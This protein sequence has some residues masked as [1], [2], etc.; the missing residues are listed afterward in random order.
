MTERYF[1]KFPTISYNNSTVVDITKR[2]TLLD[3]VYNNPFV[4][5]PYEISS[6]ERADQL[7]S[8]YYEDPF[9]SWIIY[10]ANRIT[11]PYYEWYLSETEFVNFV[12][13]KYGSYES[14]INK[15]KYYRND[16]VNREDISV[17][18]FNALPAENK[19]YWE[20]NLGATNSIVSYKRSQKDWIANT[21]KI[22]SYEV[23]D[24]D[25]IKDEICDIVF[26]SSNTG[27][28]QVVSVSN[29]AVYIQHVYGTY[30]TSNTVSIKAGSYVYG[31]ESGTNTIFTSV[32]SVASNIQD[33][34]YIYWSPVTYYEYESE[35][36]E[37]NKTLRT[38][39]KD[40]AQ[41]ISDNLRDYMKV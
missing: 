36:N 21:N 26:D 27:K 32:S 4:F 7:S 16:W 40:Y 20:P 41:T 37:Y 28:G 6:Y 15:I 38:L 10:F 22:I 25:F 23:S 14:A 9:Q 8:R 18:A 35:K 2:T 39:D 34:E 30:Y 1:E 5:Y 29:S 24:T 33:G 11:D 31:T 13:K 3:K 19:K 12:T 17:S